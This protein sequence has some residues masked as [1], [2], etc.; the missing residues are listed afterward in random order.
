M[1]P[2]RTTS[3]EARAWIDVLL[4]YG[5][6][7]GAAEGPDGRWL[8]RTRANAPIRLLHGPYE[9]LELAAEFQQQLRIVPD[10]AP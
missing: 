7:H 8:I 3:T 1:H 6:L 2:R 4:R 9:V 5:L 10:E